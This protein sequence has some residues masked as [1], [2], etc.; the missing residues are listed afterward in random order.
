MGGTRKM[1]L[2]KGLHNNFTCTAAAGGN[3]GIL[4]RT[5]AED[6]GGRSNQYQYV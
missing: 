1:I 3:R 6:I 4:A 5:G 2:T